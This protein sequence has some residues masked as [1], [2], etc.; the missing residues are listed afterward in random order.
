VGE[1]THLQ[2]MK[3]AEAWDAYEGYGIMVTVT[4]LD[5]A[6]TTPVG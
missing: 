4:T 2:L 5:S 3:K 6:T 1:P